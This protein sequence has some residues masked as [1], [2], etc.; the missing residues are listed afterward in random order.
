M[1]GQQEDKHGARL[2]D[3]KSQ[4]TVSNYKFN[5]WIWRVYLHTKN[6]IIVWFPELPDYSSD[7]G[8]STMSYVLLDNEIYEIYEKTN[9][10][11]L[12]FP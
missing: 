4:I 8:N 6:L 1:T 2:H 12:I 10:H 9:Y 3:C 7:D 11:N 5:D